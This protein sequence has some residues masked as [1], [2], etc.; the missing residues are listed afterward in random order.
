[1]II[2]RMAIYTEYL[3][4]PFLVLEQYRYR[5]EY[6]QISTLTRLKA[7]FSTTKKAKPIG[8]AFIRILR[9]Y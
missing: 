3:T 2:N 5:Q 1:M 8:P 9:I 6:S 4:H 7:Y